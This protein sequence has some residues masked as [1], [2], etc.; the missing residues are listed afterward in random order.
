M[1]LRECYK[2]FGGDYDDT[3]KRLMR[4][5]IVKKFLKKFLDDDS[6]D[7]L[8][9]ALKTKNMDEAFRAA[10][11]LKGIAI[12]LGLN[13]LYDISSVMTEK[14]RHKDYLGVDSIMEK[15]SKVYLETITIISGANL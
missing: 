14:L 9:K 7:N 1:E 13:N 6:Y 15:L 8:N 5:D 10:H 2:E 4:E 3:V 11:T 12:N